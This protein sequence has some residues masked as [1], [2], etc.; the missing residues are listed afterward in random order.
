[1]DF[2]QLTILLTIGQMILFGLG[3]VALARQLRSTRDR[4]EAISVLSIIVPLVALAIS[5]I[6]KGLTLEGITDFI[7]IGISSI[8]S[9]AISSSIIISIEKSFR[10]W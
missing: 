10:R 7:I 3:Y 2:L 5:L 8:V 1:M 4:I 9:D 6:V